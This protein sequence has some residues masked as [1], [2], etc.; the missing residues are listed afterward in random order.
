MTTIVKHPGETARVSLYIKNSGNAR[1]NWSVRWKT[2]SGLYLSNGWSTSLNPGESK[3]LYSN[4]HI[5]QSMVGK[6]GRFEITWSGSTSGSKVTDYYLQ[7]KSAGHPH[8]ILSSAHGRYYGGSHPYLWASVTVRNNGTAKGTW[9]VTPQWED[10]S[11][12][13]M[14]SA[15][16]VLNP[17]Q[18]KTYYFAR[19]AP[20]PHYRGRLIVYYRGPTSGFWRTNSWVNY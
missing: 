3:T 6:T 20:Q 16:Y 5:D 13:N 8:L 17:G 12:V 2:I 9:I 11:A 18:S 14:G 1:G 15:T 4:I 7:V 19:R 10:S